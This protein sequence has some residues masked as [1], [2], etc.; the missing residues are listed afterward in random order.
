MKNKM[1]DSLHSRFDDIEDKEFL[2]LATLLDPRYKDKFFTSGSTRQFGKRLLLTEYLHIKEE[3]EIS[4]PAAKRVAL[5]EEDG[6][7]SSS[8]LW[9]CLSEILQES[10]PNQSDSSAAT[11]SGEEMEPSELE[12]NQFLSA[13]LLDFKKGNPFKWWQDNYQ[14][15][16]I[17][18][19]IAQRYL[20]SQLQVFIQSVSFLVL[21]RC[22]MIR[23]LKPEVQF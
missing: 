11:T 1:L 10:M 3:I 2:V 4:E 7:G 14:C 19:Q 22:M 6:S 18:A 13:P 16:S 21:G 20:P 17:L 5:E 8:K 12:V 15:Y 23:E 9:G